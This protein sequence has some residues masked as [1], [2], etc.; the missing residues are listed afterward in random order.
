MSAPRPQKVFISRTTAGLKDLGDEIAVILR[1]R[2][3]E[4]IIQT[5]FLPDWRTVPQMLQDQIKNCD[6]VIALIGPAHGGEP[7]F[8]PARLNDERTHDRKFSFTQWEYLVARDLK[9]RTFTFLL[10]GG[11]LIAP[12]EEKDSNGNP[13]PSAGEPASSAGEPTPVSGG[14]GR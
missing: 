5:G 13:L 12:Y 6:A 2:G 7:D 10:S 9:R 14:E 11:E 8:E 3:I 1:E 4:V